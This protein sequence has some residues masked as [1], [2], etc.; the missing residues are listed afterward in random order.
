M[1]VNTVTEFLFF[2]KVVYNLLILY[3]YIKYNLYLLKIVEYKMLI[4]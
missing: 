1:L 4:F 3:N 2:S